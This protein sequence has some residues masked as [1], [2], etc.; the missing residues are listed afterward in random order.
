M[1]CA[2]KDNRYKL[3]QLCNTYRQTDPNF[4][5]RSLH[6]AMRNRPGLLLRSVFTPQKYKW[7]RR[8]SLDDSST[9]L[10]SSRW[11]RV[12]EALIDKTPPSEQNSPLER[13][14]QH[15]RLSSGHHTVCSTIHVDPILRTGRFIPFDLGNLLIAVHRRRPE[16][17]TSRAKSTE[18]QDSS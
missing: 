14:P 13:P 12:W 4:W 15:D 2:P 7:S 17:T 6:I 11:R 1:T 8:C 9:S 18:E 3:T 10:R 16:V 5:S